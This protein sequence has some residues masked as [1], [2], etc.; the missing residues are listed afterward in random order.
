M[1]AKNKIIITG[2]K[3]YT[4]KLYKHLLKE[5]PSTKKRMVLK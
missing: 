4:N 2:T 3:L 5:H 1:K